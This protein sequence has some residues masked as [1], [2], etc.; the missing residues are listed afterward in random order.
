MGKQQGLRSRCRKSEPDE[1]HR[2]EVIALL[3]TEL[4][5]VE[6]PGQSPRGRS[7]LTLVA[8]LLIIALIVTLAAVLLMPAGIV[9]I[10]TVV[11]YAEDQGRKSPCFIMEKSECE[12]ATTATILAEV[13]KHAGV[14]LP[15][16]T[17]LESSR[18]WTS[19]SLF[20]DSERV[21]ILALPSG[22]WVE[23]N[24]DGN[25]PNNPH[26]SPGAEQEIERA[27]LGEV[28]DITSF[29]HK[30]LHEDN[31]SYSD[32]GTVTIAQ[33]AP[34]DSGERRV[35]IYLLRLD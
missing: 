32:Y 16:G 5:L 33:S 23:A 14:E 31:V 35:L 13:E 12:T 11:L 8:T 34:D 3:P 22:A 28:A 9:G 1:R 20:P 30:E 21:A 17:R 10:I 6:V 27:D 25:Y 18:A 29:W 4:E 26:L 2:Q 19:G 7:W 15:A 24:A